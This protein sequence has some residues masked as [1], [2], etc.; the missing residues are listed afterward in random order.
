MMDAS[1]PRLPGREV[2]PP[3]QVYPAQQVSWAVVPSRVNPGTRAMRGPRG[4]RS[5]MVAES[6]QASVRAVSYNSIQDTCTCD[7]KSVYWMG[8]NYH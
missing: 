5:P 6:R 8:G 7:Y 2:D 1:G 4:F 3:V